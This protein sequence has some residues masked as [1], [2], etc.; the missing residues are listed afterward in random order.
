MC[1]QPL[2]EHTEPNNNH[3]GYRAM[4]T[5][6]HSMFYTAM[7]RQQCYTSVGQTPLIYMV[8]TA[9]LHSSVAQHRQCGPNTCD[10]YGTTAMLHSNGTTAMA[11]QQCYTAVLHSTGKVRGR[12]G[13]GKS[14]T[15]TSLARNTNQLK[16]NSN[17]TFKFN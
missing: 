13:G 3:C 9:M 4:R 17:S 8:T 12:V 1:W 15:T 6:I 14:G 2:G 5:I 16:F 10:L 7:A 11:R